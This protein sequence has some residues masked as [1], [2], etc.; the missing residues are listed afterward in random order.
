MKRISSIVFLLTIGS[1]FAS[2]F[3]DETHDRFLAD[4]VENCTPNDGH[5]PC[6]DPEGSE[7]WEDYTTVSI[8]LIDVTEQDGAC[9]YHYQSVHDDSK[10]DC[11]GQ[12]PTL[13]HWNLGYDCPPE[14]GITITVYNPPEDL[15]EIT[16]DALKDHKPTCQHGIKFE[17]GCEDTCDYTVCLKYSN[18]QQ[19]DQCCVGLSWF[20][21]KASD[22][23]GVGEIE[24]PSC[25]CPSGS[26]TQDPTYDPTIDPTRDP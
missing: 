17:E 13:S 6:W 9:C 20:I 22:T 11:E 18:H 24:V 12:N 2:G 10:L 8:T 19:G 7:P 21:S 23:F 4:R 1:T 25:K 26:P 5:T 14:D 16:D 15:I 3:S